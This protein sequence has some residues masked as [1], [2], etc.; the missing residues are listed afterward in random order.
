MNIWIL[1]QIT[2]FKDQDLNSIANYE[3]VTKKKHLEVRTK[4]AYTK[5]FKNV[6]ISNL[7]YPYTIL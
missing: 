4:Y 7:N 2:S 5:V 1:P 6:S 3:Q